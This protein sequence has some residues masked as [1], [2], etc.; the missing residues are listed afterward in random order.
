MANAHWKFQNS[1]GQPNANADSHTNADPDTDPHANSNADANTNTDRNRNPDSN[2]YGNCNSYAE[3]Y[4]QTQ[5]DGEA[6]PH[7]S[8]SPIGR[9]KTKESTYEANI[10]IYIVCC[11]GNRCDD[12]V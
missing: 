5:C 10:R 6:T 12:W 7:T 11:T 8:A 2:A 9:K 1:V 4:C 3:R